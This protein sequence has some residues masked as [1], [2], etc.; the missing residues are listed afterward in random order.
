MNYIDKNYYLST[1]KGTLI[2]N[3]DDITKYIKK[4]CLDIDTLTFNRIVARGFENLT[5]FQQNI[6][7]DVLCEHA[8]FLFENSDLLDSVLSSYSINGVSMSFENSE[9][10]KIIDGVV[11]KQSLYQHLGQTGLTNRNLRY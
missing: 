9:N 10:I 8:E 11:M 1:Y 6:I 7:K 3:K 5:T 4:A 2:S